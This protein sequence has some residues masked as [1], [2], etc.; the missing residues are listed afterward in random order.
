MLSGFSFP[1]T[2]FLSADAKI[3][4]A[5][6][7]WVLAGYESSPTFLIK[8]QLSAIHAVVTGSH[9]IVSALRR[10]NH[11]NHPSFRFEFSN[12]I[13]GQKEK[14]FCPLQPPWNSCSNR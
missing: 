3:E 13:I 7:K 10:C 1:S 8:P 11:P 2:T 6:N 5:G 12:L 9:G 14:I 4:P